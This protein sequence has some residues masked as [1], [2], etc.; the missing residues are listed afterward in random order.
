MDD[1]IEGP[2][3]GDTLRHVR[4]CDSADEHKEKRVEM[5]D[6]CG[7]NVYYLP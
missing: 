4:V 7:K 6:I 5:L 3:G 2:Q 1:P